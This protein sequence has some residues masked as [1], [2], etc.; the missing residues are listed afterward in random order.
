MAFVDEIAERLVGEGV[1]RV[2]STIIAGSGAVIPRGDGPFLT[3]IET[4]GTA[5]AKTHN[6]TATQRPTLQLKARASDQRQARA[7]L[8]AAYNA[9]GGEN[10]LHNVVLSDTFYLRI[11]ARQEPTDT[12]QEEG[13]GRATFT[14]NIE[15]E[16]QPS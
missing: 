14:F 8:K 12:G 13:T 16:K 9:L 4:G 6:N 7:L 11:V 3:L 10:G 5:S 15:V 1:G 2:G